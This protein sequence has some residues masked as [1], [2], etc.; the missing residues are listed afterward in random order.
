M[1]G[2]PRAM[3]AT[4]SSADKPENAAPPRTPPRDSSSAPIPVRVQIIPPIGRIRGVLLM[5]SGRFP[6]ALLTESAEGESTAEKSKGDE[7]SKMGRTQTMAG[8]KLARYSC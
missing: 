6:V 7:D 4:P 2:K 8:H 1:E 5:R 3:P